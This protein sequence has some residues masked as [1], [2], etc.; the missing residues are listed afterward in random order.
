MELGKGQQSPS[1][2]SSPAGS[3]LNTLDSKTKNPCDSS[4]K[5]LCFKHSYNSPW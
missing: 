2:S 1:F 4:S 3:S 5:T